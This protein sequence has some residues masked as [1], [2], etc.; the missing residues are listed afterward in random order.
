MKAILVIGASGNVGQAV[1]HALCQQYTNQFRL[2]AA[3][4]DP[5]KKPSSFETYP[6]LEYRK[7]DFEDLASM[8]AALKGVD[9]VFLLRPP[10]IAKVKKYFHPLIDAI[11]EEGIEGLMF[12]SVQGVE[13]SSIIP[14]HKIERYIRKTEIPYIFLRP[15]Y[16]MQNL[17]TTLQKDI[18]E[19]QEIYLPAGKAKF[20]WVDV[21]D[22]GAV[23]AVL[24]SKFEAYQNQAFELTGKDQA[25]FEE[26]AQLLSQELNMS[27]RY[28][29]PSLWNFYWRKRKEAVPSPFILVMIMLHYLPRFQK[30]APLS[31]WVEQLTGQKPK[32]LKAFIQE[33]NMKWR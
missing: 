7:F 2:V 21:E 31:D 12:L 30:T 4:R 24:F 5:H 23:A 16:F 9:F 17:S 18:Q 32:S 13:Q 1:I 15:S 6:E 8:K 27:I 11:Q 20:T 22:I 33:H 19:R 25:G 26:V 14:H 28:H 3:L 29:S 10:A